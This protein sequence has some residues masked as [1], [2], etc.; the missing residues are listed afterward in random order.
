VWFLSWVLV[1][2]VSALLLGRVLAPQGS[3]DEQR[4]DPRGREPRR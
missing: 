1:A 2:I 3:R 4:E